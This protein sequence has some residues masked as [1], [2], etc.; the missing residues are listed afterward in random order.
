MSVPRTRIRAALAGLTTLALLV[1]GCGAGDSAGPSAEPAKLDAGN[2]PITPRN[3]DRERTAETGAIQEALRLGGVVPLMMDLD[4]RLVYGRP[5]VAGKVTAQHPPGTWVTPDERFGELVPGLIAG[6]RTAG[7]RRDST[8][9]G[10]NAE[11]ALLRFA[12]PDLAANAARVLAEENHRKYPPKGPLEIAGHPGH[13]FLS[14][15]DAVDTWVSRGDFLVR[16]YVS[17][18]LA[19]PPDPAPLLDFAKRVL[20]KQFELLAGFTPTVAD[21]LAELPVD[22]E[23]LLART[24]PAERPGTYEDPTGVYTAA[25]DLHLRERPDRMRPAYADAGVDLV[26]SAGSRVYRTRDAAAAQRLLAALSAPLTATHYPYD[27]PPG[28][29]DAKCYKD[30]T[31]PRFLCYLAYEHLVAEVEA[32]QPADLN[33]RMAAQYQLLTHGR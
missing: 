17:N 26:A 4:S 12:N 5:G 10:L 11:L 14:Q 20:D 30:K 9:L 21:E 8:Q 28:L 33:Q 2:Y 3:L 22:S 1:T 13:S 25:A 24:L 16:L 6:W 31:G 23:G 18:A 19:T 7:S 27:S 32:A 15:Y 29:P